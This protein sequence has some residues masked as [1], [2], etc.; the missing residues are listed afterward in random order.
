[1]NKYFIHTIELIKQIDIELYQ[2][3]FDTKCYR[4][5]KG[6]NYNRLLNIANI[7][8]GLKIELRKSTPNESY[9][10]GA[11]IIT[12]ILNPGKAAFN[13]NPINTIWDRVAFKDAL[14]DLDDTIHDVFIDISEE[15][16]DMGSYHLSRIDITRDVRCIPE[17][18]IQETNCVLY[19][20]PLRSGY[21]HNER[22][23]ENCGGTFHRKNSFNVI[24][25]SQGLEFVTYNKRQAAIDNLASDDVIEYYKDTFRIELRCHNAYIKE[26]FEGKNNR[27]KILAAYDSMEECVTEVYGS[28]FKTS[29]DLCHLQSKPLIDELFELTGGKHKRFKRMVVLLDE[30]DKYP[31]KNIIEGLKKVYPSRK[32]QANI[33]S[34]F[35]CYGLSPVSTRDEE[36]GFIQSI[37]SLLGFNEPTDND[38]LYFKKM[39]R[40]FGKGTLFFHEPLF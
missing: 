17:H 38:L 33:L 27:K 20:M 40:I 12:L 19:K 22:L 5:K 9:N 25:R 18:I 4:P 16:A 31:D 35:D 32:K 8:K 11:Y 7:D 39:E 36:I 30:L 26:H 15:L 13:G 3:L 14:D 1:M 29:T 2:K 10:G 23:E 24:N 6:H 28:L 21:H 37:D 34:N